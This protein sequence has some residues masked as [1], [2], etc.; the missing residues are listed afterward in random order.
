MNK[1]PRMNAIGRTGQWP[2]AATGGFSLLEALM[3]ATVLG[4]TVLAVISAAVSAQNIS[5]DG[6]KR[7][8]GAIAAD[9]YMVELMTLDYEALQLRHGTVQAP[10]A[11]MTVDGVAYPD[12]FWAIGRTVDVTEETVGE[13]E[14]GVVVRGLRVVVRCVD[15]SAELSRLEM[16][17]PEPAS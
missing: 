4:V 10:G 13:P 17:V 3:A 15:D 7:I 16:F 2:R 5:F 6:Q 11:M 9:D 14:L 1:R 8:L 12:S